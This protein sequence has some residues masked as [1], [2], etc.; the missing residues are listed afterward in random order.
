MRCAPPAITVPASAKN[1]PN[2]TMLVP[3]PRSA[4]SPQA[5][6]AEQDEHGARAPGGEVDHVRHELGRLLG[7]ARPRRRN[8]GRA[9]R[10]R[11]R[12]P[13]A[14]RAAAMRARLAG[15]GSADLTPRHRSGG[16]RHR[17]V[18]APADRPHDRARRL[19]RREPLPRARTSPRG[20]LATTPTAATALGAPAVQIP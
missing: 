19:D 10:S 1:R 4:P 15:T 18:G 16:R 11:R 9:R 12:R 8:R 2:V 20:Y 3:S 5:V 14:S 7:Q 17:A 6:A 13:T